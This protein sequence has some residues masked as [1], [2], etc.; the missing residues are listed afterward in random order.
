MGLC[1][2]RKS[3]SM[4]TAILVL[5]D[6]RLQEFLIP[7]KVSQVL[8][9]NPMCFVCDSEDMDFG[10]AIS[11][12]DYKDELQLGQ[13]YFLLPLSL[14]NSPLQVQDMAALAV[15][16]SIALGINANKAKVQKKYL[17]GLGLKRVDHDDQL[18]FSRK[19]TDMIESRTLV[20]AYG[21][22]RGGGDGAKM[23]FT[24]KLSVIV[25]E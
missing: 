12:I 1:N 14:L 4:D 9:N 13:L 23:K 24:A 2:S 19:R 17:C 21:G 8:E 22:S 10:V 3:T 7:V 5:Q 11:A 6:G 15:R 20:A 25:E 18:T 16:A